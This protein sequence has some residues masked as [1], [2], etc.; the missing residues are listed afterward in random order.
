MPQ[1]GAAQ[2]APPTYVMVKLRMTEQEY[3]LFTEQAI[4]AGHV[5]AEE[6]M[7]DRLRRHRTHT[8][9]KHLYFDAR[10]TTELEKALGHN[11]SHPDVVLAQLRTAVT[12]K[13]GGIDVELAPVLQQR[14]KSRVFRG[15]DY[16]SVVKREVIR[17]LKV[18]AGLLPA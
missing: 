8:D 18:F 17:G 13:V 7:L 10:Q 14:I 16:A 1:A 9:S 6:E 15:E 3:D 2:P 5:T 12:L 4:A 11:A